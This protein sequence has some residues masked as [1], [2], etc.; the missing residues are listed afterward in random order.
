MTELQQGVAAALGITVDAENDVVIVIMVGTPEGNAYG[1]AMTPDVAIALGRSMRD[2]SR[3]A[4]QLQD[5][6][7]D[8]DPEEIQ[9]RLTAIRQRYEARAT[10]PEHPDETA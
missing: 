6:L 8:L 4:Q 3:E 9:D 10:S 2:M 5:E 1:V 7:D